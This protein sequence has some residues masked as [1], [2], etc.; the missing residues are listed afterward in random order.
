MATTPNKDKVP[1]NAVQNLLFNSE[2]M[3]EVINSES[4]DYVDRLGKNRRTL[5]GIEQEANRAMSSYGYITKTSFEQGNVLNTPNS[6]LLWRANGEFYRWDGD[7]SQPKVVPAGSTPESTGGIGEG[8]WFSVGDSALRSDLA[9]NNGANSVSSESGKTVQEEINRLKDKDIVSIDDYADFVVNG[10]WSDAVN[11]AFNTGLPVSGKGDYAVSKIIKT[12][13][14]MIV[15]EFTITSSLN[16][17]GAV[18]AKTIQPD[19]LSVRMIYLDAAYDLVDLLYIKSLGFNTINHYARFSS[20]GTLTNLLDNALTAGLRVNLGT[21]S[22]QAEADLAAFVNASKDHPAM[23]GYS[24]F[25]EPATRNKSVAVQDAKIAQLRAL[26][27][28][29]LSFVDRIPDE[30]P[31]TQRFS[32]NYDVAFVNSYARI[33]TSGNALEQDLAKM[34]F[35]FGTV[36]AMTGVDRVIPVISAFAFNGEAYTSNIDQIVASSSI[37]GTVAKG[38]FGAFVWDGYGDPKIIDRV[39]TNKKLQDMVRSLNST[40]VRKELA[41]EAVLFGGSNDSGYWWPL[42]DII[43]SIPAKDPS[44]AMEN[45]ATKSYPIILT[46]GATNTDRTFTSIP[47]AK[48]SGIAFKGSNACFITTIK[49]RANIRCVMQYL[50]PTLVPIGKLSLVTTPD[51]GYT[52]STINEVELNR[53]TR[54]N[55]NAK[56]TATDSTIGISVTNHEADATFYRR[57]L[58]GIIIC[59]D[60]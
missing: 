52:I 31:F 43:K 29:Q 49:A 48:Y 55:F 32:R 38:S 47:N 39:K 20:G 1:S 2:K 8:K 56:V 6:V 16:T 21:E 13:G 44:T 59:C 50:S 57:F 26:T 14:Q 4:Y 27:T 42:T 5:A 3:D 36:K 58:M 25:D 23:W 12:K 41:T 37:F 18:L 22:I 19:S 34:R 35:D 54:I 10:D 11:A 33:W 46:S 9:S 7:W 60:W 15:G 45:L 17:L 30:T 53:T 24:V 51:G 28:H 40:P